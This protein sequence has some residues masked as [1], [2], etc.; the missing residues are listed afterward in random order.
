MAIRVKRKVKNPVRDKNTGHRIKTHEVRTVWTLETYH[1]VEAPSPELATA[2][3]D[4]RSFQTVPI[5]MVRTI[6]SISNISEGLPEREISKGSSER[7]CIGYVKWPGE[8]IEDAEN[9]NPE[10]NMEPTS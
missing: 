7:E 2:V 1:T 5:T 9:K 3:M 4:S 10:T 8:T 6:S